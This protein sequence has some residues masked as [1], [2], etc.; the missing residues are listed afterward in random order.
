M[1]INENP[2]RE[3]MYKSSLL[4]CFHYGSVEN[5]GVYGTSALFM[6]G[7]FQTYP[8]AAGFAF[9]ASAGKPLTIFIL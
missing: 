7:R 4:G 9:F 2:S 5:S 1:V 6:G 8:Y 3:R